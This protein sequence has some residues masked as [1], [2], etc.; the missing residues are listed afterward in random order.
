M[1]LSSNWQL[2]TDNMANE[3]VKDCNIVAIC[4]DDKEETWRK[5]IQGK[6]WKCQMRYAGNIPELREQYC[7]SS[8]PMAILI[9]PDGK[10]L[11]DFT[12]LPEAGVGA[13]IEKWL[14]AHPG[15]V[16]EGTWKEN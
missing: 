7:L 12:R 2:A 9:T 14:M 8:L 13:Q 15:Q 16:G 1:S 5:A 6:K 10:Y 3:L 4:M 11:Q